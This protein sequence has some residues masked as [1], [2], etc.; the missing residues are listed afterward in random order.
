MRLYACVRKVCVHGMHAG[1]FMSDRYIVHRIHACTFMCVFADSC[2]A[3]KPSGSCCSIW[4]VQHLLLLLCTC[5]GATAITFV[6]I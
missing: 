1:T 3:T 6:C 5:K 2:L 4:V